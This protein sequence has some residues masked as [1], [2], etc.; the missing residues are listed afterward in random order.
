MEWSRSAACRQ[1]GP[2]LYGFES[3][4]RF[5]RE[6]VPQTAL[7]RHALSFGLV[8]LLCNFSCRC[9]CVC[10]PFCHYSLSRPLHGYVG[11]PASSLLLSL[12]ITRDTCFAMS[13]PYFHLEETVFDDLIFVSKP[14]RFQTSMRAS[15]FPESS[16]AEVSQFYFRYK[17]HWQC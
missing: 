8:C 10:C 12:K 4:E 2:G 6:R 3:F 13:A 16:S 5:V 17:K 15:E 7:V 1:L 11:Q 14:F 9:V